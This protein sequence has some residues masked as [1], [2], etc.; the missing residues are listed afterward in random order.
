[1]K[2]HEFHTDE[3]EPIHSKQVIKDYGRSWEQQLASQKQ[4][5]YLKNAN[6]H[7][8]GTVHDFG[9]RNRIKDHS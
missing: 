4:E 9:T 2:K 3:I 8:L 6:G 5:A 1:M 7:N